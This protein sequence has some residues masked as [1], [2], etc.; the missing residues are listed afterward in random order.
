MMLYLF[1]STMVV[2]DVL[3]SYRYVKYYLC[4]KLEKEAFSSMAF[5]TLW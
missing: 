2:L 5:Y 3:K 4:F 1:L